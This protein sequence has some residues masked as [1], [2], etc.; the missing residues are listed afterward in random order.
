MGPHKAKKKE[1]SKFMKK[2]INIGHRGA[3]GHKP[4]N[5]LASIKKAVELDVDLVEIDVYYIDGN[6]MVFHD[7]RLERTTNGKGYIWDSTFDELRS[8][9]AGNGEF[10][11][12]LNEVCS[13]I[14]KHIKINIEIKGRT[15]SKHVVD[16]IRNECHDK[17]ET[18]R[19]LV[20]SFIHQELKKVHKLDKHIPIGALCCAE[21]LKLAKF[22]SKLKA[23]SVNPSIEFVTKEFV[24]DAHK[25]GL[26]VFVYTVNHPDDIKRMHNLG[27]DGIFSNFPDRVNTFNQSLQA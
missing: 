10:I 11:P 19:F 27:V 13:I 1:T 18:Q 5:T 25:R 12:T 17:Q 3:M 22:G 8:L 6:L 2:L 9:D 21:P 26:K 15:A 4:E 20:S 23:F 14:P 24:D 7:D 16:F